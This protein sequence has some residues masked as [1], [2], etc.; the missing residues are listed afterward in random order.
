MV[1]ILSRPQR[2]AVIIHN[3]VSGRFPALP[4]IQH[5]ADLIRAY[6]WQ[7]E[8]QLTKKGGD[9]ARLTKLAR[10]N[11]IDAVFIAGGDGSIGT[12]ASQLIG[13]DTT[14][15][16]MPTGTANV[17]ARELGL[18][19]P[20][21][22]WAD[23]LTEA[24]K[25]QLDGEERP[26]DVGTCNENA[27]ILWAGFGFDAHVV[28]GVEPRQPIEKRFGKLSYAAKGLWASTT[29]EPTP[30]K[31]HTQ[32]KT[33]DHDMLFSLITNIQL[34]A[35]GL[36]KI[37]PNA[38]VDDGNMTLWAFEGD[39]F[40]D[41]FVLATRMLQQTHFEHAHTHMERGTHFVIEAPRPIPMQFDGEVM[42]NITHAEIKIQANALKVF[43][44][45]NVNPTLFSTERK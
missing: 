42:G 8:I 11:H 21:H 24:V 45:T 12:A 30:M 17:W 26:I 20:M 44:T 22:P 28:A 39:H 36:A 29:W 33:Y 3:P 10:D 7:V 34:Y 37:D 41:A 2:K 38:R 35:G 16:I 27:F 9:T 43:K 14:L 23:A 18:Y 32:H 31:I 40:I 25:A 5:A 13:S 6:G 19:A 4:L 1:L 15:G